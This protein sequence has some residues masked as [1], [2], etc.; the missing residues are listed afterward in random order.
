MWH[1]TC[2]LL[3]AM[4]CL[5]LPARRIVDLPT[6]P[7]PPSAAPAASA[8]LSATCDVTDWRLFV[9]ERVASG[10][11][12]LY[13]EAIDLLERQVVS[14]VLAHTRGNQARAARILGITRGNLR[15]KIRVLGIVLRGSATT[16]PEPRVPG[17][18]SQ[19]SLPPQSSPTPPFAT[20]MAS[21][22]PVPASLPS[23]ALPSIPPP[24]PTP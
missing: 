3:A 10:S 24:I 7:S 13:A 23:Y 4:E 12:A 2:D 6:E 18:P 5:S 19:P 14:R 20:K 21:T 11:D 1:S 15:K 9:H 8:P 16:V 22:V 17:T